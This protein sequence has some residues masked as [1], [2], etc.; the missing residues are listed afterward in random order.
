[1]WNFREQQKEPLQLKPVRGEAYTTSGIK[2]RDLVAKRLGKVG[3][4]ATE[5]LIIFHWTPSWQP[6]LGNQA[7]KNSPLLC[8]A[9]GGRG[10]AAPS[11]KGSQGVCAPQKSKE[12]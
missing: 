11:P 6:L 8:R 2:G 1:M 4:D 5:A 7:T 3:T 9:S 10:R 12:R